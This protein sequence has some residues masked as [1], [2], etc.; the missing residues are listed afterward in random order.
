MHDLDQERVAREIKER[1]ASTVLLQLPDG[2]RP[3][4]FTLA[5]TLA[6]ETGAEIIISGDS[7]Y[8]A[9]DLA[10][11]QADTIDAD[12]IVHYGHS[13]MIQSETPVLYVEAVNDFDAPALAEKALPL[14][15]G[16]NGVGLTTTIQH[17]HQLP[18]IA[19]TL[20]AHGVR[21]S[22]STGTGT[23]TQTH[24]GQILGCDYTAARAIAEDIEGY[25]HI[26][27]GL[28]HPLGLAATTGKPI[29]TANPYT[30]KAELLPEKEVTRLAMKRMAAIS[31]S[32]S[33]QTWGILVS[34]KPGQRHIQQAR[35]LQRILTENRRHAIIILLDEINNH[36]LAN[37]T[38][39]QAY[40][41]TACPR[42]AIDNPPDTTRPT[43]TPKETL[44]AL[45]LKTWEDTW[46]TN[47][48]ETN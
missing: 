32:K 46:A 41:D 20:Q 27:A 48:L 21:T 6:E 26:G 2:L 42:I 28:F 36:T 47:Y 35:R 4:A 14:I 40:V 29:A 39:P 23:G 17:V 22:T 3:N 38:E 12:L 30:M 9:C 15:K 13:P 11:T 18:E 24:P 37:F 7:C 5:Q 33:A 25:L 16:W 19:D 44:I 8:G 34:T 31:A 1:K 45:N 10:L 43:L